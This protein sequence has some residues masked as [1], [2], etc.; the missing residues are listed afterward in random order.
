MR[1]VKISDIQVE[2]RARKNIGSLDSLRRSIEQ[3]GVLQPI[4]VTKDLA[5]VFGGRRL[6]ASKDAGLEEIPARV[7]D[8]DAADPVEALKMEREEN[9]HRKDLTPVELTHL[10]MR[11]E[12]GLA[13][14]HGS[15]QFQ[16]KED[17]QDFACPTKGES[18]DIAAQAVNMNRESYRQAKAVVKSDDRDLIE[19]MDDGDLSIHAAYR[20]LQ[21]K[22]KQSEERNRKLQASLEEELSKPPVVETRTVQENPPDVLAK[23]KTLEDDLAAK[24]AAL[25]KLQ[26]RKKLTT[27]FHAEKERL[28][29][30][31]A[32]LMA[33]QRKMREAVNEEEFRLNCASELMVLYT[34]AAKPL[35]Q[36]KGELE[37]L[38]RNAIMHWSSKRRLEETN[39]S[40][41]EVL[42]VMDNLTRSV[43]VSN[44]IDVEVEDE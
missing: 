14:R 26:E 15:N 6:Q 41:G 20:E 2:E 27:E 7:F 31:I 12:E 5:L 43:N 22:L 9:L 38:A 18:R 13:A 35:L 11:I 16:R 36:A 44:I 24:E 29:G 25:T 3:M 21:A 23:L 30:E 10:A 37:S 34:R 1:T 40:L 8:I 42:A 19:R 17:P 39:A 4:G 32:N 28:A 33:E